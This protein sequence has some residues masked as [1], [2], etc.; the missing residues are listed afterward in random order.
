[1]RHHVRWSVT[2]DTQSAEPPLL[3]PVFDLFADCQPHTL[4]SVVERLNVG[5]AAA[6][7]GLE[8]LEALGVLVRTRGSTEMPVWKRHPEMGKSRFE[9]GHTSVSP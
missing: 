9:S 6:E 5:E 8:R 1:M 3:L 2:N 7:A 4:C